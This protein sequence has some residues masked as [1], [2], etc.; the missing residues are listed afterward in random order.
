MN[1]RMASTD[2][3]LPVGGGE[4][5][6]SPLLVHKGQIVCWSNFAMQRREDIYGE[7]ADEFRPERWEALRPG[8]CYIPFNG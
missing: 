3:V 5:G 8:W 6:N 7:D 2:T 4:D 1:T